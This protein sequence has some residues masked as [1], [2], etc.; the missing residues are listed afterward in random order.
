MNKK[1]F[2]FLIILITLFFLKSDFALAQDSWLVK[3]F[4]DTDYQGDSQEFSTLNDCHIIKPELRGQISSVKVGLGYKVTLWESTSCPKPKL[5]STVKRIQVIESME[6]LDD[7]SFDNQVRALKIELA[8][9]DSGRPAVVFYNKDGKYLQFG[10]TEASV[11]SD[12]LVL[13]GICPSGLVAEGFGLIARYIRVREGYVVTLKG[14]S[15][16]GTKW[17]KIGFEN[18]V[19]DIKENCSGLG[20]S[21]E[22]DTEVLYDLDRITPDGLD[23]I[24]GTKI[25]KSNDKPKVVLTAGDGGDWIQLFESVGKLGRDGYYFNDVAQKVY[26]TQPGYLVYFCARMLDERRYGDTWMLDYHL[27]HNGQN[28]PRTSPGGNW[29][30]QGLWKELSSVY[31]RGDDRIGRDG[32]AIV[33]L[34]GD[35]NYW[36]WN[37]S[38][39]QSSGHLCNPLDTG[40]YG[41]A[42]AYLHFCNTAQSAV[43]KNGYEVILFQNQF[44]S[45]SNKVLKCDEAGCSEGCSKEGDY[46]KCSW[47]GGFGKSMAIYKIDEEPV[48]LCHATAGCFPVYTNNG[49]LEIDNW[50]NATASVNVPEGKYAIVYEGLYGD[51]SKLNTTIVGLATG[52]QIS[53]SV[54]S[55]EVYSGGPEE[56]CPERCP[57]GENCPHYR[58]KTGEAKCILQYTCGENVCAP[59]T[60]AEDCAVGEECNP[61]KYNPHYVCDSGVCQEEAGCERDDSECDR[62][63]IDV[64]PG[65]T[66]CV[67]VG[68]EEEEEEGDCVMPLTCCRINVETAEKIVDSLEE[69]AANAVN[70]TR[71]EH[72]WMCENDN[73]GDNK[74]ECVNVCKARGKKCYCK[75]G[76]GAADKLKAM[77]APAGICA[78]IDLGS[79]LSQGRGAACCTD[80]YEPL[81]L[82]AICKKCTYWCALWE[83]II[84]PKLAEK[85][86]TNSIIAPPECETCFGENVTFHPNITMPGWLPWIGGENVDFSYNI[87]AL[88]VNQG[89]AGWGPGW[90]SGGGIWGNIWVN[91]NPF[92]KAETLEELIQNFIN[93]LLLIGLPLALLFFILGGVMF[94]TASGNP[95]R[96]GLAR[97]IILYTAI[98]LIVI[99]FAR[100]LIFLIQRIIGG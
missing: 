72:N 8:D 60:E 10:V 66:S 43:I 2:F 98:G 31:I 51:E 33:T 55:V 58:C 68:E 25:E 78:L 81:G 71:C 97:R 17:T 41:P 24:L 28:L 50:G 75:E 12:Y 65:E 57:D 36:G 90:T 48:E 39:T 13:D 30:H 21:C 15:S 61:P 3:V 47:T 77:D 40:N 62:E 64:I 16:G 23:S 26:V 86:Y 85:I 19:Y 92:V 20:F 79:I 35:S 74:T 91:L 87:C 73:F 37:Q 76:Y 69:A 9:D 22:G 53:H 52:V 49:R 63:E 80:Y 32:R 59:E 42:A 88:L 93:F 95:E 38:F 7:S 83:T 6:D 1:I 29:K 45:G 99:L 82:E 27:G 67:E 5:E 4:K 100:G 94:M 44:F 11:G 89:W 84:R 34:Y 96:V 18:S 46:V 54:S 70:N 14:Y 56:M